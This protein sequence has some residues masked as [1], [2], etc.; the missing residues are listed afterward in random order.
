MKITRPLFNLT[1]RKSF[2]ISYVNVSLPPLDRILSEHIWNYIRIF[3]GVTFTGNGIYPV[4][5]G[6]VFIKQEE[7]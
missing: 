1:V 4:A 6:K 2:D 5:K 3:T 7:P